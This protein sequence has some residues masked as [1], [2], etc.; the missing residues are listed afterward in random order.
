MIMRIFS[1]VIIFFSLVIFTVT[2]FAGVVIESKDGDTTYFSSGKMKNVPRGKD[3][4]LIFDLNDSTMTIINKQERT[5]ISS[6]VKEY[7]ATIK[8]MSEE[9]MARISPEQKKQMEQFMAG[10]KNMKAPKVATQKLGNGGVIAGY[11]TEKYLVM[12]DGEK[13]EEL[14]LSE[15]DLPASL[16]IDL[17][18]FQAFNREFSA[19]TAAA[20]GFGLENVK[21]VENDPAYQQLMQRGFPLKVVDYE[22]GRPEVSELVVSV[23]KRS[24]PDSEFKVPAGYRKLDLRAFFQQEMNAR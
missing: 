21:T 14:Y 17:K 10:P 19:C 8:A 20:G 6:T 4:T 24:L 1:L 7:C 15:K 13:Y 3:A 16:G 23:Q 18:I 12:A 5:Y 2:S 22:N 11:A 9:A